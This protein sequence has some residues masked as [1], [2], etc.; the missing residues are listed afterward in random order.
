MASFQYYFEQTGCALARIGPAE[1]ENF[2]TWRRENN[3][4]DNSLRKQLL[5]LGQFFKF[6]RKHGWVQG[7]PF[8]AGQDA[9]VVVPVEQ[10]SDAMHVLSPDEEVRYFTAALQES[11]DLHDVALIM[12]NQGLRPDEVMSLR[13]CHV[14]LTHQHFSVWESTAEGKS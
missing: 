5:L 11:I 13:Q 2:K 1:L 7:D 6:S 12:L 10:D 4:H 14:D 9:E 8:A 3:V